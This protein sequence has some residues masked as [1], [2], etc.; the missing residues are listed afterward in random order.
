MRSRQFHQNLV[1][2]RSQAQEDP[3]PIGLIA[4][5]PHES[6]S[7]QP[8]D[9]F[10]RR[11]RLQEQVLGE[12]MDGH[13][14]VGGQPANRKDRLV[15]LRR[16]TGLARRFLAER[17]ECPQGAPERGEGGIVLLIQLF[18][19]DPPLLPVAHRFPP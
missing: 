4:L 8:I 18:V 2:L 12:F 14:A 9:Q 17:Q 19:F 7:R 13:A 6:R 16:K 11:L 5:A 1:G 15:L 10:D 3:A